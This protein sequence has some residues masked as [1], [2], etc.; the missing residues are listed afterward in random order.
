M[1]LVTCKAQHWQRHLTHLFS[2]RARGALG[3]GEPAVTL[4]TLF[5]RR[6]DESDKAW[7]TLWDR[8][9]GMRAVVVLV[10]HV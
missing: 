9:K 2:L 5:T 6:A 8:H 4:F 10:P 1:L 3:A 7:M